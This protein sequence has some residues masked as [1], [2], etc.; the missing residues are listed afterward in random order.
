VAAPGG[1][2]TLRAAAARAD[3][4]LGGWGSD[5]TTSR[6]GSAPAAPG[7]TSR[8]RAGRQRRA[9]SARRSRRR[10]KERRAGD[11]AS[12]RWWHRRRWSAAAVGVRW[13]ASALAARWRTREELVGRRRRQP[14]A[15]RQADKSTLRKQGVPPHPVPMP[16]EL[17]AFKNVAAAAPEWQGAATPVRHTHPERRPRS[18][19]WLPPATLAARGHLL[20]WRCR[21]RAAAE[22]KLV[23]QRRAES[24]RRQAATQRALRSA[25]R[26][27]RRW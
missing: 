11:L 10:R 25:S 5:A 19:A 3:R 15:R 22:G 24:R 21:M 6:A 7:P 23:R 13:R 4:A 1:L 18:V 20:R 17:E 26:H 27:S 2:T 12:T 14:E 8:R 9:R 16:E